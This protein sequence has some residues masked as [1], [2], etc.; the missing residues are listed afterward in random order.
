[1]A[2]RISRH[3]SFRLGRRVVA[4]LPVMRRRHRLGHDLLLDPRDPRQHFLFDDVIVVIDN[5]ARTR[6]PAAPGRANT[7][8]IR[9]SFPWV[10]W[11]RLMRSRRFAFVPALLFRHVCI[12]PVHGFHVL[13]QRAGVGVTF[14]AAWDFAHIWFLKEINEILFARVVTCQSRISCAN[15]TICNQIPWNFKGL[16]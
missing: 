13:S 1:M 2:W 4:T 10:C 16:L 11:W 5:G 9:I 8:H 6:H 14:G 7:R 15:R 3:P 12:R